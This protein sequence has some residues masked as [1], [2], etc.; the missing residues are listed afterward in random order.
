V[1]DPTP[2]GNCGFCCI[3]KALSYKEDGWF[4][5]RKEMLR[6]ASNNKRVYTKAQ[7]GKKAMKSILEEL[8]VESKQTTIQQQQWLSKL[9][10]GQIAANMYGRPIVFFG[11]LDCITFVPLH[12][13]PSGEPNPIYLL[14]INNNHWVLPDVQGKE[15]VKPIPPPFLATRMTSK[16]GKSWMSCIQKGLSLYNEGI[17]PAL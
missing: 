12:K 5:V 7:G 8:N 9:S 17:H 16:I 3:A 4:Q 15:G 6:E 2:D 13:C 11:L 1:F 10:H 14:H